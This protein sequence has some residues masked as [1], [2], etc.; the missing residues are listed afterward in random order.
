MLI[1]K[2]KIY[3]QKKNNLELRRKSLANGEKLIGNYYYPGNPDVYAGSFNNAILKM[4]IQKVH[5]EANFN[6][7]LIFLAVADMAIYV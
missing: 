5:C 3:A 2:K 7:H 6:I 4:L 1:M